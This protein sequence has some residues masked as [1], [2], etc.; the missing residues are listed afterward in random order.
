LPKIFNQTT[1]KKNK[2]G[3][4][5]TSQTLVDKSIT[6][7]DNVEL[8]RWV[9]GK[10]A[11]VK[12]KVNDKDIAWIQIL[13]GDTILS[14]FCGDHVLND[15]SL[16][17][18]PG[19]FSG[20][21]ATLNGAEILYAR[22]PNAARFDPQLK[23]NPPDFRI[24]DWSEEPVL[25][26]THDARKRIYFVTP[27]LFATK[28]ISGEMIIYPPNTIASNHYHEDAEH[29]QYV[30]SGEGVVYCNEKPRR[31]K[32]GDVLYN[33]E[34]ERHYF[35]CDKAE[36]FIFVEFFVPGEYKTIW[37]DDA[38]ICSWNPSGKNIKGGAPSRVIG[39]HS[40]QSI[41]TPEDV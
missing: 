30:I 36:D 15:Q 5:A 23:V 14:G 32:P 1:V 11:E 34:R 2:L 13:E 9:L 39:A 6:T 24:V 22:I 16:A 29:F 17:F 7:E 10:H 18:M 31:L 25:N 37:V 3:K 38:P 28:A 20:T 8:E 41:S 12:T 33:Y 19:K 27:K 26:S 4:N 35:E 40:S 21:I